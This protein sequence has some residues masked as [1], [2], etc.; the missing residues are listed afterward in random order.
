MIDDSRLAEALG[1]GSIPDDELVAI[2]SSI[3][4][5]SRWENTDR[6]SRRRISYFHPEHG[7]V[8]DLIFGK[9]RRSIT[10]CHVGAGL[11]VEFLQSLQEQCSAAIADE[12]GYKIRRVVLFSIPEVKGFWK[13]SDEWQILP[14][15]DEAP[16]PGFLS[17]EH[18]FTFEFRVCSSTNFVVNMTRQGRRISELHC[19]L[20]L[21]LGGRITRE[22]P[23]HPHH[24]MLLREPTTSG[25]QTVYA[26][27]GYLV[28]GFIAEADDFTNVWG[29]RE[30][31]VVPDGDYYA[32]RGIGID[33]ELEVPTCLDL[34]FNLFENAEAETRDKFLRAAYWF[35]AAYRAWNTS[36]ALSYIAAIN[37]IEVLVPSH[38][39]DPCPSCKRDRSPGPTKRFRDFVEEYAA[40]ESEGARTEM[41]SFRSALVHGDYLHNMDSPLA[42]GALTPGAAEHRE[43]HDSALS[44]ARTA[45]RT[46]L[47]NTG[48][49]ERAAT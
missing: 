13:H 1:I 22:W 42:W 11:T 45:L 25:S 18:P 32:R 46:W 29:K 31:S 20:S 43:L 34:A 38:T 6:G 26:N 41:Y 19:L 30:L 49:A 40:V 3:F 17:G 21:L 23:N 4:P 47:L 27:E 39:A 10:G 16:R 44:V 36:K 37:A 15:P 5:F 14:A 35:D 33:D 9:D 24:W 12:A 8:L 48:H 28:E 7:H 2:V